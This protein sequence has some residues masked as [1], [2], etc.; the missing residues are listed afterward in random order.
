MT[1]PRTPQPADQQ[2]LQ[3]ALEQVALIPDGLT[4]QETYEPVDQALTL[5]EERVQHFHNRG[6]LD[7]DLIRYE[8]GLRQDGHDLAAD[9]VLRLLHRLQA[10][11]KIAAGNN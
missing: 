4:D 10:E 9:G 5:L 3:Q 2:A 11:I 8:R 7:I 1:D 6:L